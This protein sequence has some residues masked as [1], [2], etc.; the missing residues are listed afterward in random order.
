MKPEP[1]RQRCTDCGFFFV[2]SQMLENGKCLWCNYQFN[3]E[4]AGANDAI[5]PNYFMP[6]RAAR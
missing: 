2:V 1:K 6:H 3:L 5:P 4:K